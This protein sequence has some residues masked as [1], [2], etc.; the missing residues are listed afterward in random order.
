MLRHKL[1]LNNEQILKNF[2]IRNF[3]SASCFAFVVSSVILIRSHIV[4]KRE[5]LQ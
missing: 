4:D 2:L 3:Q 1:L 5:G